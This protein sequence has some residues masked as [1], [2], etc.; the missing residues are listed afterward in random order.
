MG[1]PD[2]PVRTRAGRLDL[3]QAGEPV[4]LGF[5]GGEFGED[6]A[7]AERL[8]AQVRPHPVVAGRGR[9]PLC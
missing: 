1:S 5:A 7:E 6:A 8:P 4:D 3:H 9:V 2:G